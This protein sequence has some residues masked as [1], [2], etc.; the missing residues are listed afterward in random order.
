MQRRLHA[1]DDGTR[2]IA[3]HGGSALRQTSFRI[4]S[5]KSPSNW[6]ETEPELYWRETTTLKRGTATPKEIELAR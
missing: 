1:I 4:S 6:V 2:T 5:I 3:E